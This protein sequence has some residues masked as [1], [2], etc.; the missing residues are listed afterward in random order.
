MSNRRL[1]IFG[2]A[3]ALV[4]SCTTDV[5]V[6]AGGSGTETVGIMGVFVDSLDQPVVGARVVALI[7]DSAADTAYTDRDGAYILDTLT[8]GTYY[9]MFAALDDSVLVAFVPGVAADSLEYARSG[10]DSIL[11]HLEG[12]VS[13]PAAEMRTDT[14]YAPGTISGRVATADGFP[15]A[16]AR[17]Y[18]PG[19]SFDAT[20]GADGVFVMSGVPPGTYSVAFTLDG[21]L[22]Q[23]IDGITV[24]SGADT[25]LPPV[26]LEYSPELAPR[27]PTGL[28]GTYDT[29]IGTACLRWNSVIVSNLQGYLLYA[30][31][32]NGAVVQLSPTI[33]DTSYCCT[34]FTDMSRPSFTVHF[35]VTAKNTRNNESLYS[36]AFTIV[37][38]SPALVRTTIAITADDSIT[39]ADT[40]VLSATVQNPTRR[41]RAVTWYVDRHDS[42]GR[43]REITG[44]NHQTYTDV[45]PYH[46]QDSGLKWVYVDVVDDGGVRWSDSVRVTVTGV[47]IP[48]DTIV[49]AQPLSAARRS[50][51]ATVCGNVLYA[52]GGIYDR[53]APPSFQPV[54]TPLATVEAYSTASPGWRPHTDM[55][56]PRYASV[57]LSVADTMYVIGGSGENTDFTTVVGYCSGTGQWFDTPAALPSARHGLAACAAGGWIYVFGGITLGETDFVVSNAIDRFNPHTGVWEQVGTMQSPRSYHQVAVC[58]DTVYIAGGLGGAE[59]YF[60]ARPLATVEKLPLSSPA[61]TVAGPSMRIPRLHFAA[62]VLDNS[63][64]LLG[65]VSS[66]FMDTP[67][68]SVESLAP[69]DQSWTEKR[70]LP[71][72]VHSCA[73]AAMDHCVWVIGGST[74]AEPQN[75]GQRATVLRYYP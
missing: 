18:I 56:Q 20:T 73:A 50:L 47:P 19:T 6:D 28:T 23:Q 75:P 44:L 26:T 57:A 51:A 65:G 11:V 59:S 71:H 2:F 68:Q 42:T 69:G 45:L 29:L 66:V 21:Y 40:L 70:P 38:A 1:G 61:S 64:Y 74:G 39:L 41:N 15:P 16:G 4:L 36:E 33:P 43:V 67:L 53:L 3:L 5:V 49:E 46:F 10:S 25:P 54:A 62:A 14:M 55:P 52:V 27:A 13:I 7:E 58:G 72:A 24:R 9:D 31:T 32:G 37:A 17:V 8:K 48:Q 35:Q 34:L 30:D 60:Q 63:V 12:G 22:S